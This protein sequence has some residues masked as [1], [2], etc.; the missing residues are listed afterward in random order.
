MR[1]IE[2]YINLESVLLPS[3]SLAAYSLCLKSQEI[4]SPCVFDVVAF[5]LSM[6]RC[7][8]AYMLAV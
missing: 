8:A 5:S 4:V 6:S 2:S 1:S 7:Q 3:L